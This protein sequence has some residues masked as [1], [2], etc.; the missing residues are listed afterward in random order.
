MTNA[1]NPGPRH[2]P[3]QLLV[4]GR[5]CLVVGGKRV[6]LRR[7]RRLLEGAA[8]VVVVAPEADP[9]IEALARDGR[10]EW[11]PREF[12]PSDVRGMEFVFCALE[13]VEVNEAVVAAARKA[14]GRPI[15]AANDRAWRCGDMTVPALFDHGAFTVTVSSSARA[16]HRARE[17]RDRLRRFCI[18]EG[19]REGGKSEGGVSMG[20]PETRLRRLRSTPSIRRMMAQPAIPPTRLIQPLFVID[21]RRKREPIPTLP[22]AARVSVDMLEKE[23]R[24][25]A[26][27]GVGAFLFFGV[28]EA[29][30][31]TGSGSHDDDG[32]VPKALRV[33]A[34]AYPEAVLITDVCL[35]AYTDHG[36]CGIIRDG[37]VDN[38]PS[39]EA[40][41]AMS[42]AHARAGAHIVAPSAMMDGQVRAIRG[43][44]DGHGFERTLI[45]SY[46]TK[47][48]SALYGPFRDAAKSAPS[49][50]DRKTYQA[51]YDDAEQAVRESL[52]GEWPAL[53]PERAALLLGAL[54]RALGV[55]GGTPV[56]LASGDV[57]RA[58]R[59]LVAP[60]WPRLQVLS[61]DEL[62][63]EQPVRPVGR[64]ELA[65]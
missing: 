47:F 49:F 56:L 17:V 32:L 1:P 43:A 4:E 2:F 44:L 37:Y 35:C 61:Y 58:V 12:R 31:P 33:A 63:P 23:M 39:I 27:A 26:Q 22:G 3:V 19:C 16:G 36:H 5:P 41:G 7:V 51:P 40:L 21:G 11:R 46:S 62:P 64:L 60:R 57:R 29:K 30:D 48:S 18:Q 65:A 13:S 15:V 25:A 59:L 10:L 28:P 6:A 14:P 45:M 8:R 34:K 24:P 50:G 20:F 54:E 38:D 55:A 9:G 52:L 42:V 53:E